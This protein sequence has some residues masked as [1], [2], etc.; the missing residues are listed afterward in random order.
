MPE[1]RKDP[2]IGRWVIISAERA[3]RPSDFNVSHTQEEEGFC[4]FCEGHERATL[5]EVFAVRKKGSKKSKLKD[6]PLTLKFM[7][8]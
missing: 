7:K 4:P 5:S 2:I 8:R 3:K 1:L 6:N